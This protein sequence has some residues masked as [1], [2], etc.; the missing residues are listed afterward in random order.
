MAVRGLG[1]PV[2]FRLTA[3]HRGDVPQAPALIDGLPAQFVLADGAYDA[4]HFRT[5]IA[6]GGAVAV[7]PNIPQRASQYLFGPGN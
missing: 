3:G 2:A 4:A 6:K 7:I 1:N 5:V